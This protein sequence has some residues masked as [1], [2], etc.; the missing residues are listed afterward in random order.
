MKNPSQLKRKTQK[1]KTPRQETSKEKAAKAEEFLNAG[2]E[3]QKRYELLRSQLESYHSEAGLVA[4]TREEELNCFSQRFKRYGLLGLLDADP[5][6][7]RWRTLLFEGGTHSLWNVEVVAV[8]RRDTA[9]RWSAAYS[10][11]WAKA[12]EELGREATVH[13]TF[14]RERA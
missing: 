10:I 1:N 2:G 13:T 9:A 12:Q 11:L 3:P 8:D 7:S 6:G 14:R 5:A 4:E